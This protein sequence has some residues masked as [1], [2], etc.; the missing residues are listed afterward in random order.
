MSMKPIDRVSDQVDCQNN[1][2]M[3]YA[4][5]IPKEAIESSNMRIILMILQTMQSDYSDKGMRIIEIDRNAAMSNSKWQIFT[6]PCLYGRLLMFTKNIKVYYW[7]K[8]IH[9][10][11]ELF[12]NNEI[13]SKDCYIIFVQWTNMEKIRTWHF[14][15]WC[16]V[17]LYIPYK[18]WISWS[19]FCCCRSV[20]KTASIIVS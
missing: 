7:G 16:Y 5:V 15:T 11:N 9:H 17:I 4:L 18:K 6:T 2:N 3:P 14:S 12:F 13:I 19:W 10:N 20:V 1:P 8:I